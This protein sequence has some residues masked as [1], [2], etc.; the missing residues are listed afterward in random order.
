M[1]QKELDSYPTL[2]D[3]INKRPPPWVLLEFPEF[4]VNWEDY[5]VSDD[6]YGAFQAALTRDP[7]GGKVIPGCGGLRKIRWPDPRR[8]KGKRGGLRVIYLVVAEVFV[9]VLVDVYDKDDTE[10]LSMDQKR[11]LSQLAKQVKQEILQ[12]A[13]R[14]RQQ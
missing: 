6:A 12:Q 10:D 3:I 13:R 11:I 8:R 14:S 9:I 4:S 5:F 7:I 1:G 2:W